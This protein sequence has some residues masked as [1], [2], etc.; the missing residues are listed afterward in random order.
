MRNSTL[1]ASPQDSS[2]KS[3]DFPISLGPFFHTATSTKSIM[4]TVSAALAPAALAGVYYFGPRALITILISIATALLSEFGYQKLVKKPVSLGDGSAFLT[5]LLLAMNIPA[6]CPVYVPIIGS[7]TA[8]VLAKQLFGGLGYTIFNP[9]LVGRAVVMASFPRELTT[10]TAPLSWHTAIDGIT[11][12]SPLGIL[13]TEGYQ[14]VVNHFGSTSSMYWNMLI[15]NRGGCLG[16][17]CSLALIAGGLF[18][19][20]RGIISW[21]I[22]LTY[23]SVFAL[24]A[25]TF[26][27]SHPFSGDALFGILAGGI[28]LGAFFMATDYVTSPMSWQGKL[29]FGAGCGILAFLIR[30]WSGYPEGVMF[31]ILIMNC[32]NPLIDRAFVKKPFGAGYNG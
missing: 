32:F 15:G 5:G 17:T 1:A 30:T 18:L 24:M 13:K 11:K 27:G 3:K 2:Q 7:F 6:S 31:S 21:H 14:A 19:L 28:L 29:I 23:L 10:W 16:E 26:G 8:I 12:A 20:A 25:F 9:A 22:P 4:W